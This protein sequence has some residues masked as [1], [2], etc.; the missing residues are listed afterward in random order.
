MR[1][2]RQLVHRFDFSGRACHCLDRV[3]VVACHHARFQR[4]VSQ[5]PHDIRG[6]DL[7]VRPLVPADVERGEALLGRPHV[8]GHHRHRVVQAN[9]LAHA[10]DRFG[11]GV[12]DAR[13]PA[14]EHGA[15]GERGDFHVRKSHVDAELRRAVDLGRRV[16]ALGGRADQLEVFRVFEGHAARHPQ[17]GGLV[18]QR[19][20]AE[21]AIDTRPDRRSTS[22]PRR[23]PGGSARPP[24]RGAAAP[25]C[26]APMSTR[27][28]L[29][30]RTAAPRSGRRRE[31]RARAVRRPDRPPAP[32]PGAWTWTYTSPVPFRPCA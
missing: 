18:D 15:G 1:Q 13:E 20:V 24:R 21:R 31:E 5:R 23:R 26:P 2:E 8:V 14:A 7:S 12:V 3:A 6:P 27:P 11:P 19:A 22:P 9:D 28:S 4:R 30:P 16:H 10:R 29:A 25:S 32:R 17:R